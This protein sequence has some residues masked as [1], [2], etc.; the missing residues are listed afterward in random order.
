MGF[1]DVL[2]AFPALVLALA[3]VA[4]LGQSLFNVTLA[5]G[6][7]VDPAAARVSRAKTLAWPTASSCWPPGPS[8]PA[9]GAS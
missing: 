1:I 3:F 7:L 6:I 8:A 4:Y 5:L 9:T 2:L